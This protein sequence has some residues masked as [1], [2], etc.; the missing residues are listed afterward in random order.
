MPSV[1]ISHRD[2]EVLLGRRLSL[3]ELRKLLTIA[4][5]PV[6]KVDGDTIK[7]EA[8]DTNRP[9]LWSSEGM[10]REI[11]FRTTKPGLRVYEL[12]RSGIEVIVDKSVREVR[13]FTA[14]SVVRNLKL[15]QAALSQMIQ[16]QEKVA[17]NYGGGRRDIAIGVY[18]LDKIKPPI[19]Y[20][21][22]E[23]DGIKFVPLDFEKELT[24]RDILTKHPKGLEFGHLLAQAKRYP[25]FIDS[26]GEVMS[27]PPIINSNFSGKVGERTRKV[28]V[29]CSGF[30][31]VRLSTALNVVSAALAERGGRISQVKVRYADRTI[32]TPDLKPGKAELDLSHFRGLSDLQISS[33][34]ARDLLRRSGYGI[35]G[36]KGGKLQVLYPAYRRDVMHERD[37]MEDMLISHGYDR[38]RPQPLRLPTVGASSE[39]EEFSG[40]ISSLMIGLGFQQV[41][42]Y[43]LTN[44]HNLFSKFNLEDQPVIELENPV[45]SS[46]SIFRN[47][48]LPCVVEF[49]SN[50]THVD[51]PQRVFEI[52]DVVIPDES[53]E[54][55][56]VDRRKLACAIAGAVAGYQDISSA[57]DAVLR[58][59][60]LQCG[61]RACSH[62]SF[63]EGR[64]AEILMDSGR[65]G[66]IG[67]ISPAVLEHWKIEVPISACEVDAGV[68]LER[69]AGIR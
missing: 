35:V 38:I 45:S 39:I 18:D 22:V 52:G 42:S 37:L 3:D 51:Y 20:T 59:L 54:T 4:K 43:T 64:V 46:W 2:M 60:G 63:I 66:V 17:S 26:S 6:E 8:K 69:V 27:I 14:C 25:M 57:L 10:A 31:L 24:P 62:P 23:P 58:S 67:E 19:R 33:R 55:K 1:E 65:I 50:N 13:P 12:A 49:L 11:R 56:A 48:L 53:R 36:E 7:V 15:D 21:T 47:W 9:D 68:L 34:E 61:L 40:L 16:L 41:L 44:R 30:D 5:C 29:E 28:F 32:L